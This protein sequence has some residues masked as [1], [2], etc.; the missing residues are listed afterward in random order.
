MPGIRRSAE[1][2][3][4]DMQD[5]GV[6]PPSQARRPMPHQLVPYRGK[7]VP[8]LAIQHLGVEDNESDGV[9]NGATNQYQALVS[10]QHATGSTDI[11]VGRELHLLF[12]NRPAFLNRQWWVQQGERA[13]SY[14][15]GAAGSAIAAPFDMEPVGLAVGQKWGGKLGG[16][17]GGKLYDGTV[18]L[19]ERVLHSLKDHLARRRQAGRDMVLGWGHQLRQK[20][21]PIA[22]KYLTQGATVHRGQYHVNTNRMAAIKDG[23]TDDELHAEWWRQRQRQKTLHKLHVAQGGFAVLK[24]EQAH[25]LEWEI[26]RKKHD[27]HKKKKRKRKGRTRGSAKRRK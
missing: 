12:R 26:V 21:S 27:A 8:T 19:S 6:G 11:T 1:D 5:G 24:P 3:Y 16:W 15:G 9:D 17:A 20:L 14:M 18:N 2:I 13:G 23:L 10:H 7:P 25:G 4:D 22:H